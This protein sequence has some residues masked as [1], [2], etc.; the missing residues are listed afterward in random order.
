[1]FDSDDRRVHRMLSQ[2]VYVALLAGVLLWCLAIV[3][4]PLLHGGRWTGVSAFLYAFFHPI[5]NQID[6]HSFHIAGE[7]TGV[8]MRCTSIYFSF[9]AGL[10]VYPLFRSIT[11][12]VGAGRSWLLA[13]VVPMVVDV[14]LSL[15]NVHESSSVT[16]VFTGA[17]FGIIAVF[18]LL[19]IIIDASSELM[20]RTRVQ[21]SPTNT[22]D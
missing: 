8:C 4:A 3:A 17:F 11:S 7:K 2:R 22:K 10:L 14:A 18:V 5:C 9:F 12:R 20:T 1:M 15:L 21:P 6:S 16:R 19:P 13:A